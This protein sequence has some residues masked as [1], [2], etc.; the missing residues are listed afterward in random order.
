[1]R[2]RATSE[3]DT[4]AQSNSN[5]RAVD[6]QHLD[7]HMISVG[8]QFECPDWRRVATMARSRHRTTS[9]GQAA[10]DFERKSG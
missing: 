8:E 7:R 6:A 3:A 10:Y 1:M 5:E 2:T 9:C 4:L